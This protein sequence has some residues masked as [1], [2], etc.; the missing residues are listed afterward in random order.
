MFVYN[1]NKKQK[2]TRIF[3]VI[4][5]FFF[6]PGFLGYLNYNECIEIDFPTSKP[7]F[8]NLDQD[9]LVTNQEQK[10][11]LLGSSSSTTIVEINFSKEFF[12]FTFRKTSHDKKTIILR[13]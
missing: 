13:C 11:E 10:F 7:K 5:F 3:L 2:W 1:L 12:L 6:F 4:S 8:E 9:Y